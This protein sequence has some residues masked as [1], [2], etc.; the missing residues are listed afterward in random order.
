MS[1]ND[2]MLRLELK[3]IPNFRE[4]YIDPSLNKGY[5]EQ[6]IPE[7]K[8]SKHQKYRLTVKGLSLKQN[9]KKKS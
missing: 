1:R 9:L 7:A 4:N 6:T 2:L 3:H 8:T 5:I